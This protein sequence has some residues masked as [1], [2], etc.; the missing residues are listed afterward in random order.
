MFDKIYF[1]QCSHC[2]GKGYFESALSTKNCSHCKGFGG[3]VKIKCLFC[4]KEYYIPGKPC[5]CMLETSKLKQ[6]KKCKGLGFIY[7]EGS[8]ICSECLKGIKA[9]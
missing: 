1:I 9:A 2:K 4:G 6:C 8:M 5:D 3:F 7:K